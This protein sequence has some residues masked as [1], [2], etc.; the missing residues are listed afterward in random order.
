MDPAE[1][2]LDN[3][4]AAG[5]AHRQL[6]ADRLDR[7]RAVHRSGGRAR[8]AGRSSFRKLRARAAA[9]GIA[10]GSYLCG[11]GLPIYWNKMPHSGVQLQLDRS[12]GVTVFCGA[13]EIGQGSDD[14]LA[15]FVAEVLGI[16]PFDIRCVTGDTDLTPVD[17]GRYSTRVTLM[18]GNAAIQAAE[19]A[20]DAARR[21]GR[22]EARGRAATALV[23]RRRARVRCGQIRRRHDFRRGGA[24][25][26]GRSRHAR[27]GRLATRRRAR[28][29]TTRARASARRR[30]TRIR[31]AW[32]RSRSIRRP[33]GSACRRSGSRTTSAARSI[34]CSR[35]ARSR[36][37]STWASARRSWRSRRSAACRRSCRARCVH[38]FPSMLEYKSPRTLDMP[39]VETY[40]DRGAG[41]E[42]PVRRQGSGAGAAACRSCRRWPTR[43]TTRSACAS[44]RCRSRP[45]RCCARWSSR[46]RAKPARFGPEHF[47]QCRIR[48]AHRAAAVG[49][50]RRQGDKGRRTK[51]Q[52]SR[53]PP[54]DAPAVVRAIARP[55]RSP[56]RRASSPARVRSDADR[57]RHRSAAEHE[58][59]PD[60]AEDARVLNRS[61]S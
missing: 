52:W 9:L 26:R 35:A 49:R 54:H 37:A 53:C 18:M 45:T 16:D 21:G 57:R 24:A 8:P 43:S 14:V 17:L 50:R 29:A 32:S 55:R 47:P 58:A 11:A 30:P 59:A 31:A 56:K 51:P 25:G 13:T 28:R 7:P 39:E 34:R 36:A 33:A 60:G 61:P 44:T 1:L 19:R 40:L 48:A 5:L 3:A 41:S 23:V 12:G 6:A 15:A 2:R 38:K 42:R 20:R 46:R 27:H 4:G 22:R 10:C